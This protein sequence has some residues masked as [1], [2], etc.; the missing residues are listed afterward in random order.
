METTE[1]RPAPAPA[2]VAARCADLVAE[3][4][5]LPEVGERAATRLR[6]RAAA[7]AYD[8]LDPASLAAALSADLQDV[9]HDLHL[10]V[11]HH[12]GGVPPTEDPAAY[13]AYWRE[14]ARTTAGGMRR[15]ERLAG[16][17]AR[18]LGRPGA[19]RRRRPR[20]MP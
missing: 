4:F 6:D 16:N 13:E 2:D 19:R 1:P 8:G 9:A 12:P 20:G 17:V 7:G 11:I 14:M 18:A 10:R 3:R 15:V 5:V